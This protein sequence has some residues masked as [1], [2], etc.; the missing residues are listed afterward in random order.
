MS[1]LSIP[2][3][4][5]MNGRYAVQVYFAATGIN[6]RGTL[7]G[8]RCCWGKSA[9]S[10]SLDQIQS[11]TDILY[12]MLRRVVWGLI[13]R[14]GNCMSSPSYL[15]CASGWDSLAALATPESMQVQGQA[16]FAAKGCPGFQLL[17]GTWGCCGPRSH[18]CSLDSQVEPGPGMLLPCLPAAVLGSVLPKLAVELLVFEL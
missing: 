4:F 14:T 15:L 7:E 3:H 17:G 2:T 18:A 9:L 6:G 1:G 8:L 12:C 5:A 11:E 10:V 16:C 13:Y